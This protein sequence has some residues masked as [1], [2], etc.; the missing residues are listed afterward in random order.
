MTLL[1]K[2]V[3]KVTDTMTEA[4]SPKRLAAWPSQL[5]RTVLVLNVHQGDG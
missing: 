3:G 5:S 1:M 4:C 2:L